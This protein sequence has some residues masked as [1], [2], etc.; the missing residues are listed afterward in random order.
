MQYPSVNQTSLSQSSLNQKRLHK[1]V[2]ARNLLLAG[3]MLCGGAQALLAQEPASQPTATDSQPAPSGAPA[4]HTAWHR[5]SY[6]CDN[7]IHVRVS[8]RGTIAQV[9]FK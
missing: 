4:V 5:V 1:F 7:N 8:Y 9:L 6:S 2:K 3:A